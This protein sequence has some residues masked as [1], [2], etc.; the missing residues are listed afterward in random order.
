MPFNPLEYVKFWFESFFNEEE[1]P[2]VTWKV[3]K[4]GV[5]A[6]KSFNHQLEFCEF[7]R[8]KQ[9]FQDSTVQI[10]FDN[11]NSV[12]NETR[13]VAS[14]FA[15]CHRCTSSSSE[16]L[17]LLVVLSIILIFTLKTHQ[18]SILFWIRILDNLGNMWMHLSK[19]FLCLKNQLFSR[20]F[21]KKKMSD[22]LP[23]LGT[24]KI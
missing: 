23:F 4:T 18:E 7:C 3:N 12:R 8:F 2:N 13:Y 6:L 20:A 5:R 21:C 22:W 9:S 14:V 15:D 1:W 19:K 10:S 16:I 17:H 11:G 24:I